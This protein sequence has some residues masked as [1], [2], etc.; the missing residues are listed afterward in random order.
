MP[1]VIQPSF[2]KGEFAQSLYGRVDTQAYSSALRRA[3]NAIVHP[4][5]G[6]SNRPGSD[7]IGPCRYHALTTRLIRFQFKTTDTYIIELG[8][9]YAR[10]IRDGGHVLEANVNVSSVAL[11]NPGTITTDAAHGYTDG[12]EVFVSDIGGTVQLNSRRFIVSNST[13][14]TFEITSQSSGAAIDATAYTAY[15]SGGTVA[16]VYQ[17]V[18]PFAH[19]DLANLKFIQSA[20]TITFTHGTYAPQELTRTDHTAWTMTPATFVPGQVAPGSMSVTQQGTAQTTTREYKVT[21]IADETFEESLSALDNTATSPVS[22]TAASPV[23]VTDTAHPYSAGDEIEISAFVEMTEL[24]GR[25][26]TVSNQAT[27]TYELKDED[28]TA[29]AAETTGGT[30]YRTHVK[31]TNGNATL[32]TTDFIDVAWA[33]V[34]GASR[35]AVYRKSNGAYGLLQETEDTFFVDDGSITPDVSDA[36]PKYR[37]PFLLA[38]DFPGTTGFYEQRQVYGGSDNKP[39]TSEYSQTGLFRNMTVSR[40]VKS[41]DAI[42]AT[43]PSREVNEILHFVAGNDL[44]ILTS[45][46]EWRVNSGSDS[47]FEAATLRQKP[48]SYWGSSH[49]PPITIGDTTLFYEAN[50]SLMRS[51]GYSL[52]IDGYTGTDMT[53]LANHLFRDYAAVESAYARTPDPLVATVRADGQIMVLTFNKAQEVIAWTTWDT[54]GKYKSVASIKPSITSTDEQFYMVVERSINGETLRYIEKT[55]TRRFLDIRDA[56]FVD[57]GLTFDTP[58]TISGVTA[59]DPAVVTA[60]AHGL[61]DGDD[62]EIF[63]VEWVNSFDSLDNEV[64]PNQLNKLRFK[65][66]DV[67]TNSFSLSKPASSILIEDISQANPG[68]VETVVA[69]G[70]TTGDKVMLHGAQGMT[71]ANNVSYTATVVD[72]TNFT[73]GVDSTSFTAY[74]A[75]GTVYPAID[76]SAYSAYVSGGKLYKMVTTLSGFWHLEGETVSLLADGSVISGLVV[77]NGQIVM[78]RSAGRIHSGLKYITD[79]ETLNIEAPS[80]TIQDKLKQVSEVTIRMDRS[81]GML[82]G[83]NKDLL[84]EMKMRE[85]E[86]YG[87]PDALISGDVKQ[88]LNPSWNDNGRVFMRQNKPLPVTVLAIIPSVEIGDD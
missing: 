1:S 10:F 73:I 23:V 74:T 14:T 52:E 32:S 42:T 54:R 63:D 5:G 24:N 69:H 41:N 87:E 21:A 75:G 25:R 46:G 72:N 49:I 11:T 20:D 50:K 70:L 67:A 77:T 61:S 37:T 82:V 15:T 80:G 6:I 36:P 88:A 78:P 68:N 84:T 79:I 47:G 57:S 22:A 12:D 40:P 51:L 64:E 71:E 2:A 83:P 9:L 76:A 59:A 16:R 39:D 29:Y 33:S 8:D 30:A 85:F 34:A 27:N 17:I 45:G 81:R 28:G 18:T 86:K 26:F 60:T 55:H 44:I 38:G 19:G 4:Y 3:R 43:L 13:P 48:Q 66:H 53:I 62:I 7:F 31:I 35:Y 65:I 56:Y 58:I